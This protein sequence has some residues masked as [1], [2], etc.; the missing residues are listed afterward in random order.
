MPSASPMPGVGDLGEVV[1]QVAALVRRQRS[2]RS[3]P[4]GSRRNGG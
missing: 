3:Q 1:E 2:G 4:L